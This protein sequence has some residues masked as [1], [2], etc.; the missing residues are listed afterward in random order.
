MEKSKLLLLQ[1]RV[2]RVG[3]VGLVS[4]QALTVLGGQ[5]TEIVGQIQAVNR[6]EAAVEAVERVRRADGRVGIAFQRAR[7]LLADVGIVY[8]RASLDDLSLLA[9]IL[10]ALPGAKTVRDVQFVQRLL[11]ADWRVQRTV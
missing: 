10:A 2:S 4:R 9:R 5:R 1:H 8:E 3:R 6:I 11:R 7:V